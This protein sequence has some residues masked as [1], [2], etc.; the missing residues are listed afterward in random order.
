MP[1][2]SEDSL[3]LVYANTILETDNKLFSMAV[4]MDSSISNLTKEI[5]TVKKNSE[6][7]NNKWLLI[8]AGTGGLIFLLWIAF[9]IMFFISRSRSLRIKKELL[10]LKQQTDAVLQNMEVLKYEKDELI[11]KFRKSEENFN[12]EIA[13]KNNTIDNL[14][15]KIK[16]SQEKEK[17]FL[18]EIS[19]L[20]NAVETT[21]NNA[22]KIIEEHEKIQAGL[23]LSVDEATNKYEE[24]LAK[25]KVIQIEKQELITQ[26]SNLT[27]I[28]NS[29]IN[30]LTKIIDELEAN[31]NDIAPQNEISI[32][33]MQQQITDLEEKLMFATNEKDALQIKYE[34]LEEGLNNN[35]QI[36]LA[37]E[38]LQTVIDEDNQLKEDL[39]FFKSE[40]SRLTN[41]IY[42]LEDEIH[43][44][45]TKLPEHKA[46][47]LKQMFENNIESLKLINMK[48]QVEKEQLE[49]ILRMRESEEELMKKINVLTD[50][51]YNLQ[52]DL[53]DEKLYVDHL[54]VKLDSYLD[55]LE[56][57]DLELELLNL[58]V[59]ER[60]MP[61]NRVRF[62]E[63][64]LNLIKIEKLQRLKE[65]QVISEE[66]YQEMKKNIIT[67]F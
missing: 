30:E 60:G 29:K 64:E 34:Q 19:Q 38:T 6:L 33:E 8:I 16:E 57:Q 54:Q 39:E 15:T 45:K 53:E 48:L 46:E 12:S 41:L 51:N 50:Q 21:N 40:K 4:A 7:T 55:E 36:V 66:E 62:D 13:Q 11:N 37:P 52:L 10:K 1:E 28:N 23:Q 43:D 63:M 31:A 44:Y 59:K 2:D 32:S 24:A 18:L 56:K 42:D 49:R 20:K 58:K 17:N 26:I 27:E 5:E 14:E 61:E 35:E 9:L 65:M 22:K 67:Q 25:F 3:K 47:A